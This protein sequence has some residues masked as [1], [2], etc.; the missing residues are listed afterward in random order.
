MAMQVGTAPDS[1][2]VW[3]PDDP[4]QPPWQQFMD[5]VVEA[6]YDTIEIGPYG[7]LPTNHRQLTTELE[8][9][10]LGVSAG[11]FMQHFHKPET[12]PDLKDSVAEV[13]SLLAHVGAKYVLLIPEFYRDIFTGDQIMEAELPEETWSK[14]IEGTH[15]L[16]ELIA[17]EWGLRA[18][19]HPHAETPVEY[20]YQIERFLADTEPDLVGLC[21]DMGHHAYRGGDVPEFVRDHHERLEYIH[22]KSVDARVRERVEAENIPFA[23]ACEMDVFVEPE[24]GVIDFVEVRRALD[25][26]GFD[27]F[28]IVE[29]DLYP[30]PIERPLPIAKRTRRYLEEIGIG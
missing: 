30:T 19:F 10:G 25:E 3:F 17:S 18:V 23:R 14:L 9:R 13:C 11:F 5:E 8:T 27:G 29:Q 4:L 24:I 6:G 28:G 7:Y 16:A 22:L 15:V 2:G 1:W 20:E 21:L 12:W 26:V